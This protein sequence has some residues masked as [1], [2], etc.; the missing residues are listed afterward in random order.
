LINKKKPSE[1][2]KEGEKHP[3]VFYSL[4]IVL[5]NNVLFAQHPADHKAN[6]TRCNTC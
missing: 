4:A 2:I 3:Y 1:G 5:L 6:A